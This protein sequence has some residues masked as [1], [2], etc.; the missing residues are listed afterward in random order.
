MGRLKSIDTNI[1]ARYVMQ[2]DPVQTR[3]ATAILSEA[4]FVS[5]TVLLETAWLLSSRYRLDRADL[6][7]TLNDLLRLPLLEV[8]DAG[9]VGWAIDR[10]AAGADFADMMHVTAARH[11]GGFVSFERRLAALAGPQSPV[12]IE[13][14]G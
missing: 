6:A 13:T 3:V 5:D 10:F 4:C 8:S 9:L 11:T 2:D 14:L 7:A 12:P 1:I